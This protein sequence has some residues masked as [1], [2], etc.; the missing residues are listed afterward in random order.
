L[1]LRRSGGG[2]IARRRR[3]FIDGLRGEV[4]NRYSQYDSDEA[5]Q[6]IVFLHCGEKERLRNRRK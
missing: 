1:R 5:K 6:K 3:I 2:I 4:A